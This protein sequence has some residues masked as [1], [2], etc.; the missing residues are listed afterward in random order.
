MD[1]RLMEL[2]GTVANTHSAEKRPL[3]F[4]KKRVKFYNLYKV[5]MY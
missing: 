5:G 2:M 4:A 3:R 1:A